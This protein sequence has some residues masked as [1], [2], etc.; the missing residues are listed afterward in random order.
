MS[1]MRPPK[2]PEKP[3]PVLSDDQIRLLWW[4]ARARISATTPMAPSSVSSSTRACASRAWAACATTRKIRNCQTSTSS[5][6]LVRITTK[7]RRELVPPIGAKTARDLDR[8]IRV[9]AAHAQAYR[10]LRALGGQGWEVTD[11]KPDVISSR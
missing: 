10:V 11:L 1:K 2:I 9:R 5:P 8:Y 6:G 4:A 7:G 3:V